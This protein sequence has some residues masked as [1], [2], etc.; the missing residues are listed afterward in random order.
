MPPER[1]CIAESSARHSPPRIHSVIP[2]NQTEKIRGNDP[3]SAAILPGLT[4]I[5]APIVFPTTTA[6]AIHSPSTRGNFKPSG[7]PGAF[8]F[9]MSRFDWNIDRENR[10]MDDCPFILACMYFAEKHVSSTSTSWDV[11]GG[12]YPDLF[13][14]CSI[15][16][17]WPMTC[18]TST[19]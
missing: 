19:G 17:R 10:F 3:A 4:N 15:I 1:G 18:V 5:P 14:L 13:N 7:D 9:L 16:I 12:C 2:T 11:C 8:C 6:I